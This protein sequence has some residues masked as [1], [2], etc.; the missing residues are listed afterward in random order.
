MS[1]HGNTPISPEPAIPPEASPRG[2]RTRLRR[3]FLRHLPIT[4]AVAAVL[5]VLTAV[6]IYFAA[7]SAAFENVVR[8]RLIARIETLTGGRAEIKS[9]HWRLLHLEAEADGVV[10]HGTEDPGE[11]PYAQIERLRVQISIFGFLTPRILLRDL[12]ID[13][14]RLHLIVYP[15]GSTNQPHPRRPGK[16]GKSAIDTLFD[17]H[18][19]DIVVEQGTLDYDSRAAAFDNQHRHLPLDF[20][21][22][23]ASLV[24]SYV[25]A[26][27]GAPERYHVDAA[28]EDLT[29][30]RDLPRKQSPPVHGKLQLALDL[31]RNRLSLRSFQLTA[32]SRGIK[33]RTLEVTGVLEDFSHPRWQARAAGDLDMRLLDPV[34]GYSDAPEG[35][36]RL[37]LAAEGQASVFH[38]DGSVHVEGGSYIGAG[39]VV[40][41]VNVDAQVHADPERLLITQIVA[42][43]RQGGQ[44]EGTVGLQPWLPGARLVPAQITAPVTAPGSEESRSARNVLVRAAVIPIPMNGKVTADFKDVTLDSIL[45]MVAAP[46]Y[47]RL[48]IDARL[49]GPADSKLVQWRR[50]HRLRQHHSELEPV[51]RDPCRGSARERSHRCHLHAAQRRRRSA[52]TGTAPAGQRIG[53]A[54]RA[55][56]LSGQQPVGA[57][58]R[59]SFP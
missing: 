43:L 39:V 28:A 37:D 5:L 1:E 52:Q 17:L 7:S 32:R 54:W 42:R 2:P 30:V 16:R 21:A 47:R 53:S 41:G 12:E 24:M 35:I 20:K 49:N 40:T 25:P 9:F 19:N 58:R 10:I 51:S 48:G 27:P 8:K 45:D 6:G 57:H 46:A 23:D 22:D 3:F 38:I 31:E 36:A 13:R 33:D 44:I 34:T 29:L 11:A 15:D 18:A 50:A 55:R 59:F 26:N 4:V 14:P 56:R